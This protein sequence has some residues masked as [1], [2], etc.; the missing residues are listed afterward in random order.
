MNLT[1]GDM[2]FKLKNKI[3][4]KYDY[5]SEDIKTDVVVI[6]GGIT[7]AIS[8]YYLSKKNINVVVVEKNIIGYGSTSATTAL[9]EYQVDIDLYKLEKMIGSNAKKIYKLCLNAVDEIESICKEIG[10]EFNRVNTLY[11]TNSFMQK[12]SILK[13]YNARKKAKFDVKYME[14]NDLINLKACIETL[15]S[16]GVIDPYK[17]TCDLFKYLEKNNVK[18]YENTEIEEISSDENVYLKT[19]NGFNILSSSA[20]FCTGFETLKYIN[21]NIVSLQKTFTIV[22]NKLDL[23]NINFTARDMCDPYHYIRFDNNRIIF[24]GE[25]IKINSKLMSEEYLE[26][27]AK[28]KYNKL[29]IAMQ[30]MFKINNIEVEYM[31][32]GTFADTIDTLPIIDEIPGLNNC[33]CNLGYGANGILYSVIGAKILKEAIFGLYTK[34][35]NM[36][37]INR[38]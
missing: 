17:F 38:G 23:N 14:N 6:G 25:D 12:S 1:N 9:L 27:I 5:L 18:I 35:I 4:K 11:F 20:I 19:T 8:A 30:K 28:E 26:Q 3:T 33:F 37:K 13:E 15:E 22:S 24:G 36:F 34:D 21:T 29:Y 2:Y 16:S 7:G 31:Y 32:N 10:S